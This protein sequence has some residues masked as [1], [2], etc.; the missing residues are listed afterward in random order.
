VCDF[1][2]SRLARIYQPSSRGVDCASRTVLCHEADATKLTKITSTE[3]SI[4]STERRKPLPTIKPHRDRHP[5]ARRPESEITVSR[6]IDGGRRPTIPAFALPHAELTWHAGNS[7][8]RPARLSDRV[9]ESCRGNP[10]RA[11]ILNPDAP[12]VLSRVLRPAVRTRQSGF[13]VRGM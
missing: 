4:G 12:Q 7:T 13:A 9:H 10:E 11:E 8:V 2:S 5:R 6:L 1:K 3:A